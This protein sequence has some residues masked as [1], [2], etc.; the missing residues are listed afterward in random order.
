MKFRSAEFKS[1]R[2]CLGHDERLGRP[3]TATTG[4]NI[5]K[6]HQIVLDDR[7]IKRREIAVAMNMFNECNSNVFSGYEYVQRM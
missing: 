2:T 5:A 1:V 7:R 4:D 6:V 3:K